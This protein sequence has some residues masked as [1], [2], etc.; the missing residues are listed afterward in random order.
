MRAARFGPNRL[1]VM[2]QKQN[3]NSA[4]RVEQL[5]R[6]QIMLCEFNLRPG[7]RRPKR[8]GAQCRAR[9]CDERS[10]IRANKHAS[11]TAPVND[12]THRPVSIGA[13]AMRAGLSRSVRNRAVVRD[14]H[15]ARPAVFADMHGIATGQVAIGTVI[16]KRPTTPTTGSHARCH[17]SLDRQRPTDIERDRKSV[18]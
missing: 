5:S 7:S 13:N 8:A 18:V 2:C 12:D 15:V 9:R 16:A 11:P 17:G 10:H 1:H 4:F 14:V 6:F 3:R